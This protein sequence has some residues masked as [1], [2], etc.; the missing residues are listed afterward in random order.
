MD[1]KQNS[2]VSVF[3]FAF[4]SLCFCAFL[5]GR[6]FGWDGDSIISACQFVRILNPGIFAAK[7]PIAQ[8]KLMSICTFG[9]FY[10]IF[11][12]LYALTF[13]SIILNS[14]MAALICK[15]VSDSGG[16]WFV[17]ML[18]LVTYIGWLDL[19]VSCDNP[20]LSIPFVF[21]GL[22]FYFHKKRKITGSLLLF[23]ASLFRPGPEII[24]LLIMFVELRGNNRNA[25]MYLLLFSLFSAG[26]LHTLFG[27]KLAMT[28]EEHT[29]AVLTMGAT[30]RYRY[31]LMAI[32]PYFKSIFTSQL[33]KPRAIVLSILSLFG[34]MRLMRTRNDIKYSALSVFTGYLLPA[35]TFLYGITGFS[36]AYH[37][38]VVIL[39][40]VFSGF[41]CYKSALFRNILNRLKHKAALKTVAVLILIAV[42]ALV[43]LR[44]HGSYEANPDGSGILKWKGLSKVKPLLPEKTKIRAAIFY[45][46]VVFFIL[47]V[48]WRLEKLD[49]LYNARDVQAIGHDDYD[50][51]LLNRDTEGY[52]GNDIYAH[53]NKIYL[54]DL[55]VIFI[56]KS[57]MVG[58]NG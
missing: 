4:S 46:D 23:M 57:I 11:G 48:G 16:L 1:N 41:F 35:G 8:P 53:F 33:I 34:I 43:G 7:L 27:Y 30:E 47:D 21:Y 6:G 13:L 44:R 54:D 52:C 2:A 3:V 40:A 36:P 39:L 5:L 22:Y 31:S 19:V 56:R 32:W 9:I 17:T 25:M 12:N 50:A 42:I 24:L 38:E 15:W 55:R 51:I 20:A 49:L 45:D 10:Q 14:L 26:L 37:I 28:K 18:G 29:K 58:K